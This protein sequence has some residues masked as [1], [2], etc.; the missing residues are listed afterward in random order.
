MMVVILNL[1]DIPVIK[2]LCTDFL[3]CCL[4]AVFTHADGQSTEQGWPPAGLHPHREKCINRDQ[5]SD[6]HPKNLYSLLWPHG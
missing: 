1:D 5:P 3:I 4:F 2:Y 6:P